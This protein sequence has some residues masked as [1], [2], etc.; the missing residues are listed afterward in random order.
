MLV[1]SHRLMICRCCP[2]K[3]KEQQRFS[4]KE[5]HSVALSNAQ[6]AY[7]IIFTILI[8]MDSFLISAVIIP[9]VGSAMVLG[10][11]LSISILQLPTIRRNMRREAVEQIYARVMEAR[12]RL[13]NTETFTNMAK[14]STIFADR[15]AIVDTPQEYYTAVSFIDLIEFLYGLNKTNMIN[16]EVWS[17]WKSLSRTMMTIPKFKKVWDK[18]KD[19]HSTEFRNFIDSL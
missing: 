4:Q 17:R 14:E 7:T 8:Y 5:I 11:L 18:T 9:L 3:S 19:I 1:L 12:M 2:R 10:G 16:A 6:N 13:E 15:F